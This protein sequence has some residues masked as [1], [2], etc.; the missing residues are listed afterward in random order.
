[1]LI[2]GGEGA[3]VGSVRSDRPDWLVRTVFQS[4]MPV[5][6]ARHRPTTMCRTRK[7]DDKSVVT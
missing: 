3:L 5:Q 4:V 1:M 2:E 6:E 7:A